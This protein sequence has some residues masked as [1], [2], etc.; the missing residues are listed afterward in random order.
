MATGYLHGCHSNQSIL[1]VFM[2][3]KIS[4]WLLEAECNKISEDNNQAA[5]SVL[6]YLFIYCSCAVKPEGV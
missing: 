6:A 3:A 2:E 1:M 4:A 5:F